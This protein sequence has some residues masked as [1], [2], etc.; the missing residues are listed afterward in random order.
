MFNAATA[1]A[2]QRS[3]LAKYGEFIACLPGA[4]DNLKREAETTS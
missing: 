1:I 2:P 3:A 4:D